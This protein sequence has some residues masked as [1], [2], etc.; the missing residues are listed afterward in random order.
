ME[1]TYEQGQDDF[2]A[3]KLLSDNPFP[4]L[5]ADWHDWQRGFIDALNEDCERPSPEGDE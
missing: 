5:T 3:G 2:A 4:P 1:R